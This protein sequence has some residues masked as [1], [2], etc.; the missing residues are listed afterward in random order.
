MFSVDLVGGKTG[1]FDFLRRLTIAK[2]AVS[3]P[4]CA[5]LLVSKIGAICFMTLGRH[6]TGSDHEP[7]EDGDFERE[8][9]HCGTI[10]RGSKPANA[11]TTIALRDCNWKRSVRRR[12]Q[13]PVSVA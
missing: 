4:W 9:D 11:F 10:A 12:V 1:A 7:K 8:Q 2:N 3:R 13:Q 5:F 6:W